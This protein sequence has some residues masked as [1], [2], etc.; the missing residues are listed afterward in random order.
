MNEEAICFVLFCAMAL[1]LVVGVLLGFHLYARSNCAGD[2]VIAPGDEDAPNYMFL[3][4][5][6]APE[7]LEKE[8]LVVLR[9][10]K[11]GTREKHRV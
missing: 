7:C 6:R 3:D 5:A 8:N 4:L 1:S 2:L 11:V 9:I 10:K